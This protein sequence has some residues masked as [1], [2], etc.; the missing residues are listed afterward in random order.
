MGYGSFHFACNHPASELLNILEGRLINWAP[1]L[2]LT[3]TFLPRSLL[4]SKACG[5]GYWTLSRNFVGAFLRC[6]CIMPSCIFSHNIIP[7]VLR[8][9]KVAGDGHS[10]V[11]YGLAGDNLHSATWASLATMF[12]EAP[13]LISVSYF[14]VSYFKS[15]FVTNYFHP[16]LCTCIWHTIQYYTCMYSF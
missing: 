11:L 4:S 13:T 12:E 1:S 9:G 10:K 5:G 8:P 3:S 15:I 16:E 14:S 2:V 7:D 6:L